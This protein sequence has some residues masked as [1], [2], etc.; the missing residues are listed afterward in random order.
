MQYGG[1]LIW[2]GRI[3]GVDGLVVCTST[4]D[5]CLALAQYCKDKQASGISHN[6]EYLGY[7]V[8]FYPGA[9]WGN[10]FTLCRMRIVEDCIPIS[11]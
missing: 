2:Y 4:A 7:A 9:V 1:G 6:A 11:F 3:G 8:W 5:S 10:W